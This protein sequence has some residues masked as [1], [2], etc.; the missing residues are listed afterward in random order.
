MELTKKERLI[1][2]NQYEILKKLDPDG[3][4]LYDR[5]QE[6]LINGYKINYPDLV[7]GFTDETSEDISEFVIDVLQM[8]RILNNS[9]NELNYEDKE[10]IRLY[11]IS[12][13][14]FDGNEEIDYYKYADFYLNKLDRF[15]ELKELEYFEVNS[16]SNMLDNYMRMV[17]SWK[18]VKS[19]RYN[20]LTLKNM[21]YIIG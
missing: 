11:D 6:I 2:Y 19:G 13:K 12:F 8:Y 17:S 1:L 15:D 14:G 5:D 7:C 18:E 9:Y 3:E 4:D 16:H 20:K 10:K 21:L